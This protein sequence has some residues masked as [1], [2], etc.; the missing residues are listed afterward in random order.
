MRSVCT[1]G[2]YAASTIGLLALSGNIHLNAQMKTLPVS[3]LDK[4]G[5]P[6]A[7]NYTT[8]RNIKS[9]G[10]VTEEH[11]VDDT[12]FSADEL[13]QKAATAYKSADYEKA[14]D[15]YLAAIKKLEALSSR[16][17][18]LKKKVAICKEA[19]AK[20]YFYWADQLYFEAW[21]AAGKQQYDVAIAKCR[22]AAEIQPSYKKK[23]DAA[24]EKIQKLQ[25]SQAY[26]ANTQEDKLVEDAEALR[27]KKVDDPELSGKTLAFS[28]DVKMRQG[29]AFY[30]EGLWTKARAVYEEVLALD[31]YNTEAIEAIRRTNVRLIRAGKRRRDVARQQY[32]SE[33]IWTPVIPLI[34]RTNA[35]NEGDSVSA[36]DTVI[37]KQQDRTINEKLDK[38]V[39]PSLDFEG[40]LV[41]EVLKRLQ[42]R[43]NELTNGNGVNIIYL[44]YSGAVK[45]AGD[46]TNA[47]D[48][49]AEDEKTITIL[50]QSVTLRHA[51]Q[52]ICKAAGLKYRI[53]DHAVVVAPRNAPLDE[54]ETRVFPIEKNTYDKL[55]AGGSLKD[56]FQ[57]TLSIDFSDNAGAKYVSGRLIVTHSPENIQKI[58]QYLD[59][60][61]KSDPQ[62]LIETKFMEV[63]MNDIEELGF[64]YQVSRQNSNLKY[65][66]KP[67]SSYQTGAGENVAITSANGK[68]YN[69]YGPSQ[70]GYY[71][72]MGTASPGQDVPASGNTTYY[73]TKAPIQAGGSQLTFRPNSA[74]LVRSVNDIGSRSVAD[75]LFSAQYTDYKTGLSVTGAVRAIDQSDS[76]DVLFCPRITT[77]NN[78][79]AT[80]KMVTKKYFPTEWEEPTVGSLEDGVPLFTPSIPELEE[81]ELGVLLQVQPS[82]STNGR[83]ITLPMKPSVK[84]HIGW[85]DYSYPMTVSVEDNVSETLTNII[86]Q[87]IFEQRVVSTLVSCDD[88]ETII[89]GGVV[90]D[91]TNSVDDQY[92][93]LGDIPLIGRL[94]QSKAKVSEKKNLL[95]FMTCRLINP[96]GTPVRESEM[97]G[98]PPFRQ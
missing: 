79:S 49:G 52:S 89:L 92:P 38:I 50:N 15:L 56:F 17:P 11:S 53:E 88:G 37:S 94:F 24:I 71:Q 76:A 47:A 84:E 13:V 14:K 12:K 75:G 1:A 26:V 72:Y 51:I 96:D 65:I 10:Y 5:V 74:N 98:L 67:D 18:A 2:L 70:N 34:P 40:E 44:P 90:H 7:T 28:I 60:H 54:H 77:V 82:I 48:D 23:M 61:N 66:K 30:A 97:R 81:E 43:S 31:P 93:L 39:I 62:V 35:Q 29:D 83:T 25:K 80:I 46:G 87:P 19:I 78:Y 55:I 86:R 3:K 20:C 73:Y 85:T 42:D 21:E 33:A 58:K 59:D 22:K 64:Q 4:N 9:L 32:M 91:N 68:T 69:L 6:A 16:N 57:K 8:E 36:E 41:S 63:S 45:K 27:K 95:I